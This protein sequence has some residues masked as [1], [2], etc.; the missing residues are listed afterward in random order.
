[1]LLECFFLIS[2]CVCGWVCLLGVVDRL[3][4]CRIAGLARWIAGLAG[5]VAGLR[6][7]DDTGWLWWIIV[8]RHLVN[9]LCWVSCWTSHHISRVGYGRHRVSVD[10]YGI[11]HSRTDYNDLSYVGSQDHVN[12]N[13]HRTTDDKDNVRCH[14]PVTCQI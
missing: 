8:D 7:V 3:L 14:S 12:K 4:G 13:G 1:M 10:S 5:R 6:L 11:M 2:G 9:G